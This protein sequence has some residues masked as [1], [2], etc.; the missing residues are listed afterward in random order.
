MKLQQTASGG[1]DIAP[2]RLEAA[3]NAGVTVAFTRRTGRQFT[4]ASSDYV[5]LTQAEQFRVN[6]E[7]ARLVKATPSEFPAEVV[8]R[9]G[10]LDVVVPPQPGVIESLKAGAIEGLTN[11]PKTLGSVVNKAFTAATGGQTLGSTLNRTLLIAGG[12]ALLYLLVSS[13]QLSKLIP[14][15]GNKR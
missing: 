8:K 14:K 12:V 6:D 10:K 7:M 15:G 3:R 2:L 11:Y 1:W 4:G 9:I 13:G 5:E